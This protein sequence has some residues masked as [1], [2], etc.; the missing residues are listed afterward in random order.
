MNVVPFF[1]KWLKDLAADQL[2]DGSVPHVIPDI[3]EA[4][5]ASAAW[6]DAAVICPWTLY[7][8]YGDIRVLEQQYPSMKAWVEYIRSQGEHEYLWNTGFHYGDWLGLDAKENSYVAATPRDLIATAYYAY[9]TQLLAQ[10]A[11]VIG[12]AEDAGKYRDL[13]G[14]IV[15]AFREEF[16]TGTG[17]VASPTQTA[18]ALALM[19]DLLEEKD[20]P[21]T[22]GMLAEHIRENGVHL[23]TGFVGTPYLCHV[24]SRFGYTD[25]AYE[26]VLQQEYPSWLYS[27]LQGAT[28]IWEHWDGIKPDGSFWSDDMNSYNHYAY[29]AVG[30]WL[31]RN[32]GGIELL[33]PGYRK[34]RIQPQPG[35]HLTWAEASFDS[36]YGTITS[37]WFRQP[38]GS[39][40]LKVNIPANTTA[41]IILPVGERNGILESGAVLDQSPGIFSIEETAGGCKLAAGSGS[42]HFKLASYTEY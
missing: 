32:A 15:R 21:R 8:C 2:A 16:V 5:Y 29:G 26:L 27:V 31:Y 4:G 9:S 20:R 24:L 25:L 40:E 37:S 39:L 3:P 36:V 30:D 41:E 22:A 12:Q 10:T 19:F 14:Q 7:Q 18:Y 38:D 13:H 34:I 42:Y 6:G 28:T 1:E 35:Q 33:E 23:T 17:R 11:E